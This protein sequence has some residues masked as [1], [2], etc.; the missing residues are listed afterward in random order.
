MWVVNAKPGSIKG[1]WDFRHDFFPRKV[2]YKKDALE[3]AEEAR[4]KGGTS[5]TVEKVKGVK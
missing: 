2:A 4:K 3:L 5:V 1:E